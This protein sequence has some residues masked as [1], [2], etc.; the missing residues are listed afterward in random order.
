MG[1]VRTQLYVRVEPMQ[2]VGGLGHRAICLVPRQPVVWERDYV[3]CSFPDTTVIRV[4]IL[5]S[6]DRFA[7]ID[8]RISITEDRLAKI[9]FRISISED[10]LANIFARID[11][12]NRYLEIDIW[13]ERPA[14]S[15]LHRRPRLV[16]YSGTDVFTFLLRHN[17]LRDKH[18]FICQCRTAD[19]GS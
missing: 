6:E 8:F 1:D 2:G 3:L 18:W 4:W 12:R 17:S 10:R 9:D 5:I 13:T 11:L 16:P 15:R 14:H 7:N 19:G